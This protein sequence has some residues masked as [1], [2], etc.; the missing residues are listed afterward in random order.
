MS[1]DLTPAQI[2]QQLDRHIV[3][4]EA[5]K[6]AV[7]VAMRSRWRR[8][9]L[10]PAVAHEVHPHN[11][12]MMGPTGCGK[13]EIARRLAQLTNAPFVK[14]EATKFTEV[15]YHGRDVD[16]MVR[17]LLDQSIQLVRREHGALVREKAKTEAYE[18]VLE[19][20]F[21]AP[22]HMAFAH[23][24][25]PEQHAAWQT[26]RDAIA[27]Q[28]RAG[29][30][31]NRLIELTTTEKSDV[32]GMM[33][34][35]G[36]DQFGPGMSDM[37]EK[38]MPGKQ[39]QRKMAVAAALRHLEETAIE[40]LLDQD[41]IIG[42][43]VRR[44]EEDGII[45]IDEI[46]KIAMNEGGK[47]GDAGVSRQGVQRDLLPIVE[48]SVIN[49]RHGAVKTDHILFIAAGAF[50]VAK[51][52]DLMP[53]LQGRFPI[54]VELE[55]LTRKDFVHILADKEN[56]LPQQQKALLQA[57]GLTVTYDRDAIETMADLAWKANNES[58]NIGARRLMTIV[59]K[60]FE[61]VNFE[62]DEMVA[63]GETQLRITER[64]VRERVEQG[65]A[66]KRGWFKL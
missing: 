62:A 15:G 32:G 53:E 44:A 5:A 17:D 55:P 4:Q 21:P 7:A 37:L 18:Q 29:E 48:G 56:A 51:V 12:I 64:Y 19:I 25:D 40:S 28:L 11:I 41:A 9:Q 47:G 63:K 6:R 13:T 30:L 16:T 35:M 22:H 60:V 33:S 2:V 46:D 14:V 1:Q 49:T 66:G 61:L 3:G 8:R 52:G 23:V 59:E 54:R 24:D 50:H 20:L 34:G 26:T 10:A 43:A 42:E 65:S 27:A 38:M 36:L 58:E 31:D 39:R 57:E 45:F